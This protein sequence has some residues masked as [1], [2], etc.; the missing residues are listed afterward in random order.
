MVSEYGLMMKTFP[1][2]L[3]NFGGVGENIY[4]NVDEELWLLA[5]GSWLEVV[6]NHRHVYFHIK[7]PTEALTSFY[8][9]IWEV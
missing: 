9:M 4:N 3:D 1:T 6:K 5:I 2:M 8:K 7:K